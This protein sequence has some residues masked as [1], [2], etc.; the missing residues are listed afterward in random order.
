MRLFYI[1]DN[2]D[3][4]AG[5][6]LAGID[7]VVAHTSEE[8]N[9]ALD[10]AVADEEIAIVLVTE[11]VTELAREKVYKSKMNAM[12]PLVTEIPDRHGTLRITDTIKKYVSEAVGVSL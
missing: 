12:R 5:L 9:T 1:S 6:R 4:A 8:V 2:I 7:G 3:T 10:Y 11:K